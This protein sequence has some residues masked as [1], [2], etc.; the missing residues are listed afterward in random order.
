MRKQFISSIFFFVFALPLFGQVD[1]TATDID[2]TTFV[3]GNVMYEKGHYAKAIEVY[4]N[5]LSKNGPSATIYY[6]LGNCY[7]K[8]DKLGP[9]VL[10]YERALFF[11]GYNADAK[12]NLDLVNL[13]IRDKMEPISESLIAI[14]SRDFIKIF[15]V[16]TWS[17]FCLLFLWI[18]L[19]GFGI[20]RYTK[21][22]QYQRFSFY[23]FFIAMVL[24]VITLIAAISR[25]NYD[26]YYQFAVIMAPSA[27]V[28]SEPNESSTNMFLIHEG[29]KVQLLESETD[30]SEIKMPDGNVGWLKNEDFVKVNDDR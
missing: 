30:W 5:L 17:L 4:E 3:Y 13:R 25:N 24:F 21:S 8:M 28:K 22:M 2:T 6:N 29:L 26:R 18:G 11:D 7:Y 16:N 1:S 12:Y 15:S 9:S 20:F 10:N 23:G 27:I 14:W 19:A